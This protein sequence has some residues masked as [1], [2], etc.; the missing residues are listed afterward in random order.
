MSFLGLNLLQWTALA[1]I[2][3]VLLAA[4]AIATIIVTVRMAHAPTG[5]ATMPSGRKTAS[6]T[7]NSAVRTANAKTSSAAKPTTSG[8]S[9]YAPSDGNAKTRMPAR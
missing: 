9:G 6:M 7:R 4:A 5:Y 1:A 8:K 2:A 3:G